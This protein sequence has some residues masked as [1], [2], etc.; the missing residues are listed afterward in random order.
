MHVFTISIYEEQHKALVGLRVRGKYKSVS[1]MARVALRD[2]L[3]K[4]LIL[5]RKISIFNKKRVVV[6]GKKFKVITK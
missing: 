3:D 4:E 2:F 6:N 1:E 5:E